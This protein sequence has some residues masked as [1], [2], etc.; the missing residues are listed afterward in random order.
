MPFSTASR[1]TAYKIKPI[2][3]TGGTRNKTHRWYKSAYG[4]HKTLYNCFQRNKKQYRRHQTRKTKHKN[5][6]YNI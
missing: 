1:Q 4:L 6:K 3:E 2:T 5:K